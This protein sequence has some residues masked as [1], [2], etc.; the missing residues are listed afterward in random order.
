MNI[1]DV[2]I[3]Y[4]KAKKKLMKKSIIP[5]YSSSD[6][7]VEKSLGCFQYDSE[8]KK[9]IDFESGVWCSNLGHSHPRIVSAINEQ[10]RKSLHSGYRFRNRESE[11]LSLELLRI[12]GFED[13]ASVFL[14]SGSEA[15]D[16]SIKIAKRLSGKK[17]KKILKIRG[18]HPVR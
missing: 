13:G 4:R 10:S 6:R 1:I 12:I 11:Q 5:F 17:K 3:G 9:F 15:V 16:L 18:S 2:S 14:S 8:G 7:I